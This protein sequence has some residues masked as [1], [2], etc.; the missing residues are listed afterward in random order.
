MTISVLVAH[1]ASS[2]ARAFVLA[3]GFALAALS[4]SS[5]DAQISEEQ[6]INIAERLQRSAVVVRAGRSSGSGFLV[7]S[8]RLVITNAHVVGRARTVQLRIG[9]RTVPGRVLA[10]DTRHDLAVVEPVDDVDAPPLP[11]GDPDR[12]RV[13]QT[14]LAFGSPFGLDGTLTQ[15]IVSARRD[16]P[17]RDGSQIEG[18]IQTDAPINPGN[19]GGPLTN[20]RGEVIGVNTAIMSRTGGSHG[21][22]FAVPSSYV[23][24]LLQAVRERREGSDEREPR[25]AGNSPA[26]A[27]PEEGEVHEVEVPDGPVWLGIFGDDYRAPGVSGVRV[28]RVIPGGPAAAAGLLGAGDPAPSVVRRLG[29]RWTGHIILAVDGRPVRSMDDLQAALSARA[30]GEHATVFVTVGPGRLNGE[31]MVQLRAPPEPA[32]QL[33]APAPRRHR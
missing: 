29:I 15:G 9:D 22:G 1:Q 25:S 32:E 4:P 19:S 17:S 11:L 14:V 7:G 18:M 12:V 24:D 26:N 10:V 27:A 20:S 21:I 28:E 6:R 23:K 5:A 8:E 16:V 2:R 13:G 3:C 33:R 30:P 31:A